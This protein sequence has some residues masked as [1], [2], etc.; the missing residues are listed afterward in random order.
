[1]QRVHRPDGGIPS[2]FLPGMSPILSFPRSAWNMIRTLRVRYGRGAAAGMLPRRAWEQAEAGVCGAVWSSVDFEQ[3]PASHATIPKPGGNSHDKPKKLPA[4]TQAKEKTECP[5]SPT[6]RALPRQR[7]PRPTIG[8][9][10]CAKRSL[11]NT[12]KDHRMKTISR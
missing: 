12:G 10:L 4:P 2:S 3:K 8:R 9:M 5:T 11:L 6:P 1:M 7:I